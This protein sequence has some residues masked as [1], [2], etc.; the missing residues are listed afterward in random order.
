[1]PKLQVLQDKGIITGEEYQAL[2][3]RILDDIGEWSGDPPVRGCT[4]RL[5]RAGPTGALRAEWRAGD[6]L[7]AAILPLSLPE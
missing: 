3:Q 5:T 1:M 4:S 7:P 6:A 2:R